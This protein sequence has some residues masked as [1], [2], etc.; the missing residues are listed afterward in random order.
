MKFFDGYID[1][2]DPRHEEFLQSDLAEFAPFRTNLDML[3][4]G[5]QG[6]TA[7]LSPAFAIYQRYQERFQQH[8]TFV[9]E[10]LQQEK[11]KFTADDKIQ[12]D[13]RHE[14]FPKDLAEAQQL[15]RQQVR[16]DYLQE[17]LSNEIHETNGV[18]TIKLPADAATNIIPSLQRRYRWVLHQRTNEDSDSVLQT[19]LNALTHAY[20][21]HSDYLN[22]PMRRIFPCR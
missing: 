1:S 14:P 10:L 16:F 21:P 3:T 2:L 5:G 17:K 4:I 6:G 13:R 15:W 18:F 20:D 19:Y 9:S 11:F 12:V 7:D 22:A 8:M